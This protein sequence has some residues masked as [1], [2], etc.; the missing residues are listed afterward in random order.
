[1]ESEEGER[2]VDFLRTHQ[3]Y[4]VAVALH[5]HLDVFMLGG[6]TMDAAGISGVDAAAKECHRFGRA[7]GTRQAAVDWHQLADDGESR[8]LLHLASRDLGLSLAVAVDDARDRF[9]LPR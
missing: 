7:T 3:T 1:M 2:V 8:F 9:D 6:D 5:H 4:G